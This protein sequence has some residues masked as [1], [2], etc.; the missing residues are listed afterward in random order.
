MA[1]RQQQEINQARPGQ[2]GNLSPREQT[3][4]A[5]P[6]ADSILEQVEV[7]AAGAGEQE[8]M[9]QDGLG[10]KLAE[11]AA[12]TEEEV[13]ALR[14]NLVQE[15]ERS[16]SRDGSGRVIDDAAEGR[17]ARF[18]ESDRMKD[19]LGAASVEPGRDDTSS[20]LRSHHL[21]SSIARSDAIIEGN[22]DEPMDETITE[23]NVDEG[24]SG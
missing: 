9:E 10:E 22:L 15:D 19:D 7:L 2:T 1:E 8:D 11:L 14:I 13:D 23:R 16:S 4:T 17:M 5:D 3:T 18:T 24:T 12:T 20:V 21:N 6:G